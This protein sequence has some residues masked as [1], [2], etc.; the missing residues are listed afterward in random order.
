M[1]FRSLYRF[2]VATARVTL[3]TDGRSRNTGGIWSRT[4]NA[5]AYSSTRRNG[6]DTDLY[7]MDPARPESNR[8]VAEVKGGGWTV[9]DWSPDETTLA[10]LQSVSINESHLH[11]LDLKSGRMTPLTPAGQTGVAWGNARFSRDGTQI[12]ARTD[13]N[14]EV[15]RIVQIDRSSGALQVLSPELRWDV[16]AFDPSPDGQRIAFLANEDGA[17]VLHLLDVGTQREIPL[18]QLALGVIT[19]LQ[20]HPLGTELGFSLSSATSPA[21]A[22]S[23]DVAAGRLTRWTESETG[24]LDATSFR[25]PERV[26]VKSFDGLEVSGFMYRPDAKKHPG[27]RPVIISIHGGPESQSRPTFL[28]RNNYYLDQLGVA[29]LYPNVRGS[30]GYGKTFLTLDNGRKR[31]DSVRDIG[32][33]IDWI[34]RRPEFDTNRIAVMGGS[35]GGYMTLASLVHFGSRLKAGVDVVGISSFVTFLENTQDYRRDLRRVEYGDERDPGMREFLN[36]ISPLGR[37]DRI[38]SPL[39][40]IQGKNDPRVPVTE[41]EQL[42]SAIRQQGGVSW[43][44]MAKDE[45]HGFAKKRNADFQFWSTV[46]FLEAFLLK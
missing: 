22:W 34:G 1:L 31:E 32:A 8:M 36:D 10:V 17:S 30:S 3:L 41:A 44:L 13:H 11:L 6:R 9:A 45:G 46:L 37:V 29:L 2:E 16:D 18:P 14:S 15:H 25:T 28:G 20:W 35:Y 19:G 7:V 38:R 12:Y 33:F 21:D 5:F 27:P 40:V 39:L 43:Y 42:V 24:G 4:G 23:L 26:R